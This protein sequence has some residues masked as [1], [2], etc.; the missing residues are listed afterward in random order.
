[1]A[2]VTPARRAST[3]PRR[4]PPTRRAG[5][6]R[7]AHLR[8][9]PCKAAPLHAE[10]RPREEGQHHA[11]EAQVAHDGH[12]LRVADAGQRARDVAEPDPHRAEG[13]ARRARGEHHD[14]EQIQRAGFT[15]APRATPSWRV[16]QGAQVTCGLRPCARR[17]ARPVSCRPRARVRCARPRRT[18]SARR[19][20]AARRSWDGEDEI[21]IALRDAL[22]RHLGRWLREVAKD[23]ARAGGAHQ[24][25]EVTPRTDGDDGRNPTRSRKTEGLPAVRA[26]RSTASSDALTESIVARARTDRR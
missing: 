5:T 13:E 21:G 17:D 20:A 19:R 16:D 11:R 1:M 15:D 2:L 18:A 23:I 4:R 6:A 8:R 26:L 25:V 14:D 7:R 12:R 9:M 24:L 3:A 22:E 10:P